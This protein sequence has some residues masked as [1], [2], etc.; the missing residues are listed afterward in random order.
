MNKEKI[1]KIIEIIE[2]AFDNQLN[3]DVWLDYEEAKGTIS[4][5]GYF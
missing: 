2:N 1:E 4:G 5:R 3:V